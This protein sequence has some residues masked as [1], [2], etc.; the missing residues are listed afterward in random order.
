MAKNKTTQTE[1]SVTNFINSV[2]DETKR[3][4]SCH[5]IKLIPNQTGLCEL[6]HTDEIG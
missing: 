1:S 6:K 5:L 4:D 3:D 2:E